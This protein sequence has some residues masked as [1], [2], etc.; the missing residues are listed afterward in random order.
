MSRTAK[1]IKKLFPLNLDR[2]VSFVNKHNPVQPSSEA[3]R[4]KSRN[5]RTTN[6]HTKNYE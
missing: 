1:T 5:N 6:S 2:M 4:S 3:F